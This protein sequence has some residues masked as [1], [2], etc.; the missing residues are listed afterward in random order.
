MIR[1]LTIQYEAEI[2]TIVNHNDWVRTKAKAV[3]LDREM[4]V[5]LELDRIMR[6]FRTVYRF[7]GVAS[8]NI[9]WNLTQTPIRVMTVPAARDFITLVNPVILEMEGTDVL[10][11]EGCGSVPD[12][13]YVVKRKP[14]VAVGGYTTKNEYVELEYGS[15]DFASDG[16]P[17][18][19][20]YKNKEWVIQHEMDHLDGITIMDIGELFD[21]G[22]LMPEGNGS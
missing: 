4:H 7:A 5:A 15:K 16:D 9:Y 14:Y 2:A 8:N 17:M 12:G 10:S 6:H 13:S 3:R 20:S 1:N 21:F 11:I 22:S 18:F 19:A